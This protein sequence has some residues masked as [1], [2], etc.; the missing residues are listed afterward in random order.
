MG[1]TT[2]VCRPSLAL[3]KELKRRTFQNGQQGLLQDVVAAA[4]GLPIPQAR[5]L[6]ERGAV[7]VRGRRQRSPIQPVAAGLTILVVLEEAGRSALTPT[8][9]P[10]PLHVLF[11]D[12]LLLVVDKPAGLPAQPTPGG[13]RSLL[14]QATEWLGRPA[15][16]VHRLDRDTTGVTVFGKT[17]EATSALAQ[18][19]RAG[20]VR[21]QYLA[22]TGPT[23][24]AEGVCTVALARDASRPGRW[25]TAA[26]GSGV[27]SETRFRRLGG[28]DQFAVAALWPR[29]GRTHQLR[30]HL[31]ALGAPIV[32]DRL[33][34]GQRSL[35][36]TEID[37]VL[38]H[39][40]MLGLPAPGSRRPLT[41][42]A[43]LPEDERRWFDLVGV[44]P[45]GELSAAGY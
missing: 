17:P 11:E 14:D 20:Q 16:L 36:G 29:T 2:L 24:A 5:S 21:K 32:G 7:Y 8:A 10:P 31:A 35:D 38:L 15:G 26:S 22:V 34:G 33:Y 13:A 9:P 44:T 6:I 43:P 18:A 3:G 25:R 4:L 12:E 1:Q 37:R 27:P 28:T 41:F 40:H 42:E 23:L 45:P 30:A 19:F 39:S